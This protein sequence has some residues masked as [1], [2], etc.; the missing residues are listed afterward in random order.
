MYVIFQRPQESNLEQ[1]RKWL[2]MLIEEYVRTYIFPNGKRPTEL[3]V[4]GENR[5]S[6]NEELGVFIP[7]LVPALERESI[8]SFVNVL[9]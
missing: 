7:E 5:L 9:V 3:F 6:E 8:R 2:R 1:A 4:L